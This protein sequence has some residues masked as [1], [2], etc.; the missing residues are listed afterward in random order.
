MPMGQRPLALLANR[1]P[2][3]P[4]G[5]RRRHPPAPS[6]AAFSPIMIDGRVGVARGQRR[7]DRGI[8]DAQPRDPVHP[9]PR[10]D[11]RHRVRAHLAGADRMV[12]RLA[13]CCTQSMISSSVFSAAP[14][15]SS[16]TPSGAIAGAVIT[17]RA[18]RIA[19]TVIS[20]STG[21][22]RKLKLIAG[23]VR[24]SAE[25][26]WMLPRALG[27]HRVGIAGHA[28]LARDPRPVRPGSVSI[29]TQPSS[30]SGAS[31]PSRERTKARIGAATMASMP[32]ANSA[33]RS[34]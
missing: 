29:G 33:Y 31:S 27:P 21:D 8:G 2:P 4:I 25:T 34:A 15:A 23:G 28:G 32:S 26:M 18:M 24:G 11:H 30:T 3:R 1:S 10:V 9:E 14:G 6:S 17:A 5:V 20:A 22:D 19:R 7:H 13:A 12:G 16:V